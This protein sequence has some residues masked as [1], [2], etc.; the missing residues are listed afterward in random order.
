LVLLF[1]LV[2]RIQCIKTLRLVTAVWMRISGDDY[3]FFN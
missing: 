3:T 1:L 2:L